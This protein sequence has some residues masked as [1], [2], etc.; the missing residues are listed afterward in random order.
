[1]PPIVSSYVDVC[2]LDV[3]IGVTTKTS[4]FRADR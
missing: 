4:G 2:L 3:A 1:M